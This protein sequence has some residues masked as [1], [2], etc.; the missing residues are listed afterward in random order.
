MT[1]LL[2]A[3]IFACAFG[4][5]LTPLVRRFGFACGGVD[6]PG[7][8][9]V[10]IR[11]I[12]RLGGLSIMLAHILGLIL[13]K[14]LGT[15][16][17]ALLDLSPGILSLWIGGLVVFG[18]GFWDDFKRLNAPIKLAVQILAASVAF[19]GGVA[20]EPQG[21]LGWLP[22]LGTEFLGYLFT[23]FWFVLLINAMNL[24]D[25]LD[26]LAGGIALFVCLVLSVLQVLSQDYLLALYFITL[27]GSIAGF[28]VYNFN[29]ATI[30]MGDGGSYYLGYMIAGLSILGSLKSQVGVTLTLPLLAMGVPVF[31]A[32]FAPVRRI[33][34]GRK[35][36]HP[37]RHHLH[38]KLIAAGFTSRRAVLTLYAA[39]AALCVLAL[40][41]VNVQDEE[42]GLLLVLMCAAV[43]VFLN[44]VGY[45]RYV[46]REKVGSWLRDVGFVTGLHRDRRRFLDFQ[47]R[48]SRSRDTEELWS[49]LVD[50]F[51]MLDFD[52]AEM[53]LF[54]K[55]GEEALTRTWVRPDRKVDLAAN[56]LFK[57][58]LPL[59]CRDGRSMGELWVVKDLSRSALSHYTLT[60]IEHLR[61]AVLRCLMSWG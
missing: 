2:F 35:P 23:V 38:H 32:L 49:V 46:D 40:I 52:Y 19:A 60:R 58:E 53:R 3:F 39:T 37:D 51:Y 36:F 57:M 48:I 26:G 30:F 31:D 33:L 54:S 28:L 47:M 15:G 1:T 43:L 11:P 8:R 21:L 9:K 20:I 17:S 25:G 22:G 13:I 55:D 7:E 56:G 6:Q 50:G 44:G 61:R 14:L 10:H 41:L 4:L 24:I 27:A 42:T 45:F 18:V 29:P 16:I 34:V 12:P 5:L 59:Q